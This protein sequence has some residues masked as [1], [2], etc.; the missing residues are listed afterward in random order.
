VDVLGAP[1]VQWV[2]FVILGAAFGLALFVTAKP[3]GAALP[4]W[5]PRAKN[6][7]LSHFLY[8]GGVGLVGVVFVQLG[9]RVL[10]VMYVLLGEWAAAVLVLLWTLLVTGLALMGSEG[11]DRKRV[12]DAHLKVIGVLTLFLV[13][14]VVLGRLSVL[15][16]L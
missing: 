3:Q 5:L 14:G 16:G 11:I 1:L 2:G 9:G 4:K 12:R 8:G 15:R 10:G 7:E 13:I 6:T